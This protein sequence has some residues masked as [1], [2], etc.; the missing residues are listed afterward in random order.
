MYKG[1]IR[2]FVFF[3]LLPISSGLVKI[4]RVGGVKKTTT[5][6][7]ARSIICSGLLHC[8]NNDLPRVRDKSKH[9]IL[10][11]SVS[12]FDLARGG[13]G[14]VVVELLSSGCHFPVL[15]TDERACIGLCN[16]PFYILHG[17]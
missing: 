1:I 8:C 7:S 16:Q 11:R 17:G 9:I 2:V 5:T 15:Y 4:E 3:F 6:Y 13:D 14:V 10:Y 12:L